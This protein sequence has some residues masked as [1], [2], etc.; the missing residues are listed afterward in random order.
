MLLLSV[1]HNLREEF[2]QRTCLEQA[3]LGMP[4]ETCLPSIN[5]VGRHN[6][7]RYIIPHAFALGCLRMEKDNLVLVSTYAFTLL[8]SW[9]YRMC[10]TVSSHYWFAFL[11]QRIETWDCE[12]KWTCYFFSWDVFILHVISTMGN[13]V[14]TLEV[15]WHTLVISFSFIN[16]NA[17]QK[18]GHQGIQCKLLKLDQTPQIQTEKTCQ[19][20]ESTKDKPPNLP[21]LCLLMSHK[22]ENK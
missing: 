6:P 13:G 21:P 19:H 18:Q 1:C 20:R 16:Q 9:L 14:K 10:L 3:G 7:Y 17:K 8:C 5:N 15:L 22:A 2:R 12:L 11:V 4:V